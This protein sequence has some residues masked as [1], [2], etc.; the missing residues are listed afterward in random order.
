MSNV[1]R[2]REERQMTQTELAEKAH[3]SQSMIVQIERGSKV[4]TILLAQDM[5]KALGCSVN[6]FVIMA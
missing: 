4:P 1:K 3:C 6:D 2:I 5:A